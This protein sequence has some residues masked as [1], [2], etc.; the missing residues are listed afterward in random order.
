[1]PID[2]HHSS[3][4]PAVGEATVP[5]RPIVIELHQADREKSGHFRPVAC[6]KLMETFRTGGLLAA[7]PAED[8]KSLIFL[9][10]FVS[11]NGD[12]G[13]AIHQ[14]CSSMRVSALKVRRRMA[15]L[16]TFHWAGAPLVV[17]H[18]RESGL[19]FYAPHPA[20][21]TH[22]HI[23]PPAPS[24]P[25]PATIEAASREVVIAHSRAKYTSSR[26]EVEK[27]IMDDWL[28]YRSPADRAR[29]GIATESNKPVDARAV[30]NDR[31]GAPVPESSG[32]TL[33]ER[34]DGTGL[35][36]EQAENLIRHYDHIRIERQLQWLPFRNAKNPAGFLLAAV[37]D[38]YEAPL[39]LRFSVKASGEPVKPNGS[40]T[41]S[42]VPEAQ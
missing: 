14:L 26:A 7:L 15:R 31:Q 19:T 11:P 2:P 22:E 6:L 34:L 30:S 41:A 8:L 21:V 40:D 27:R 16:V 29:L 3:I 38:N 18:R 5:T 24:E 35:T 23:T 12:C 4:P 39:S 10:T 42:A 17:E 13:A 37:A 9:L 36:R 32:G 1:M 33:L 25:V 20:L 28:R